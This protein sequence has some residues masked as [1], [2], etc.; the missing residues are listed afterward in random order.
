MEADPE[1]H[2]ELSGMR[3]SRLRSRCLGEG[4]GDD[5]FY[6]LVWGG[7]SIGHPCSPSSSPRSAL[8][9]YVTVTPATALLL[10]ISVRKDA[11]T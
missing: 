11:N 6:G 5:A 2:A 7:E 8:V 10:T 3:L 9:G 4:V 1:L